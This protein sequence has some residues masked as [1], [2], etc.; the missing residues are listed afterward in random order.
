MSVFSPT[1]LPPSS[2]HHPVPIASPDLEPTALQQQG[3]RGALTQWSHG[4]PG[5]G[6][7]LVEICDDEEQL[8]GRHLKS[9]QP[10]PSNPWVLEVLFLSSPLSKTI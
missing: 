2:N 10:L 6:A 9:H 3:K 7:S 4:E 1:L 8:K 5:V